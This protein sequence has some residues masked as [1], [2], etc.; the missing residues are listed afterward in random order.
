[1]VFLLVRKELCL[2]IDQDLSNMM[3]S[4]ALKK[5]RK[6]RGSLSLFAEEAFRS[7][8]ATM[9]AT[10]NDNIILAKNTSKKLEL[11]TQYFK[12]PEKSQANYGSEDEVYNLIGS[13]LDLVSNDKRTKKKYF[14]L[15][16]AYKILGF[17][18]NNPKIV[19]NLAYPNSKEDEPK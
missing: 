11:L 6:L 2:H 17:H 8:V 15:L 19:V 9:P 16:L 13:L 14:E 5:Y 1:M 12:N 4:F 7:Y 18:K 3:R 10:Y